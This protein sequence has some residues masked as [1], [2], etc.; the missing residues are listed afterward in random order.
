MTPRSL[1]TARLAIVVFCAA[2]APAG[3]AQSVVRTIATGN[4]PRS[5]AVDAAAR[6][7]YVANE[8]SNTVTA[9]DADTYA[10]TPIAV[11]NRPQYVAVN[12]RTHKAF[13]SHGDATQVMIDGA[14]GA[15]TP[16]PTNGNGPMVVS[17]STNI[18]YMVRLGP[19][20]EVTRIDA[21]ARTWYSMATDSYSPVAEVLDDAAHKLYVVGYATGD[22]RT[23][24]ITSSSDHPPTKTVPVWGKPTAIAL[25]PAT[26]KLWVVGEDSRGPINVVDIATNTATYFAPAG[27][28]AMGKAVAVNTKTNKVYAA[29][30]GEV[31]VIDGATHAMNFIASGAVGTTGPVA[32][33]VDEAANRVYV[34]NAQGFVTVIDG[35]TNSAK[36]VPVSGSPNAIALDPRTGRVFVV[37]DVVSVIDP[38][39]AA[40]T[41]PPPVRPAA[42]D[43]QGLWWRGPSES[44]WGI[45]LTHQG[46]TLFA[47]W[48]TYGADGSGQW[49]VMSNGARTGDQAYTGTLYRTTGPA[50]TGTF[51]PSRVV[52]TP[53]GSAT[54]T[55]TDANNGTLNATLDGA[56]FTRPIVRETYASPVPTCTLGGSQGATPNYQD[57]WWRSGGG[58]PGWGINITHQGDILFATWFT[59]DTDG[60][61]LWLVGPNVAR[62]GNGTYSGTL[63]RTWGAPFNAQ[64]WSP[65]SVSAMPVGSVS[66]TFDDANGGTFTASVNGTTVTRPI[67]REAFATPTSVCG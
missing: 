23:V 64:A 50:Y 27:H 52:A 32:I 3:W 9:I 15:T 2:L 59:Y 35:A 66:F 53:V 39:V 17:E 67:R 6:R 42:I 37:S 20:D 31:A 43:V 62:T 45:N 25:D 11:S 51:D 13:A 29:F 54:F 47:T 22:V 40:G 56:S 7:V 41:P 19:A 24:D 4:G 48:F 33:A 44:G 61:G 55:F 60:K 30:Q 34:A 5:I 1:L 18:V 8:F 26:H 46:D 14:T 12:S 10:A 16:L 65:S 57:L 49:L 38:G 28:A 58:E 63:Y 36:Q 21:A